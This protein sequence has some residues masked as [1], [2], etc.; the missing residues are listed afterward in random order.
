MPGILGEVDTPA[1]LEALGYNELNQLCFE[2]RE[3]LLSRVT[4]NGGHLASNLGIVELTI[5]LH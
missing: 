1:N 3:L 5:A 4:E 2:I